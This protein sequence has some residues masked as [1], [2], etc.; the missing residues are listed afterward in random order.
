[1]GLTHSI[2][3]RVCPECGAAETDPPSD[4]DYC[5]K[6]GQLVE[7]T[8]T[9]E[10]AAMSDDKHFGPMHGERTRRHQ[11]VIPPDFRDEVIVTVYE[12]TSA[13]SPTLSVELY[14]PKRGV[15]AADLNVENA[16]RLREYLAEFIVAYED[17]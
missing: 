16:R 11:F 10:D 1:M 2:T 12:N 9:R 8:Y 5:E 3:V 6:G 4:C 15:V 7:Q 14:D 17:A 13:T